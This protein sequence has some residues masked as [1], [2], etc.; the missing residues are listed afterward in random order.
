[1]KR[2]LK[3]IKTIGKVFFIFGLLLVG[4]AFIQFQSIFRERGVSKEGEKN[5]LFIP[6]ASADAPSVEGD[7]VEGDPG[8]S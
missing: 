3:A 1:M 4:W 5:S 7:P 6:M 2:T 8:G